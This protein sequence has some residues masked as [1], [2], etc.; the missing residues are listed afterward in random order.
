[1]ISEV[2]GQRPAVLK[3]ITE[4][5]GNT[6]KE[7]CGSSLLRLTCA[8]PRTLRVDHC[9]SPHSRWA[10]NWRIFVSGDR[11]YGLARV[12]MAATGTVDATKSA[13]RCRLNFSTGQADR[14]DHLDRSDERDAADD[15]ASMWS[16][17]STGGLSRFGSALQPHW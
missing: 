9:A 1:M 4:G 14:C 2:T 7:Y 11:R 16:D 8:S 6:A 13:R 5:K 17:F 10:R 12:A 15:G 3:Y